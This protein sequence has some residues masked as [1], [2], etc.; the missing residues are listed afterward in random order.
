MKKV[1]I[2][3]LLFGFT[4]SSTIVSH[5]EQKYSISEEL[6]SEE[7][8]ILKELLEEHPKYFEGQEGVIVSV[9]K[10]ILY[11]K[12]LASEESM[13]PYATITDSYMTLYTTVM[14]MNDSKY[15]KF[16]L[17]GYFKWNKR[18][19][20]THRDGIGLAWSDNFTLE[21]SSM[22]LY[23]SSSAF[24]GYNNSKSILNTVTPEAGVGYTFPIAYNVMPNTPTYL[25]YGTIRARVYKLNSSGSAN[26]VTRYVHKKSGVNPSFSF[27]SSGPSISLGMGIIFDDKV[28]YGSFNY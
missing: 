27:S 5:A 21:S 3:L 14:K 13:I 1:I 11:E 17:G 2:V 26:V 6:S 9:S 19:I 10:E 20:L 8:E 15:D 28:A 4:I 22:Q 25:S 7:R 16:N 18:P 24:T 23:Y 12:D